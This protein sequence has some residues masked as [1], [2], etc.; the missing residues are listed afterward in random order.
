MARPL[1]RALAALLVPPLCVSCREPE[2]SGSPVCPACERLM[3]AL[4]EPRCRAC[5]APA[6]RECARCGECRGRGLAFS[7]AWAPFAYEGIARRLVAA[8]KSHG[9]LS[10]AS[11]MGAAVAARAPGHMLGG[12]L[13]P[14]PAHPLR[15]RRHGFNQARE[16]AGAIGRA[17]GLPVVDFLR[18]DATNRPQVGLERRAR[19]AN[20]RRSV[21][22]AGGLG[23]AGGAPG[24]LVLVDDVYTTG[25]TLDACA[26]ALRR[27]GAGD[28]RALTF[29]R[30][31]RT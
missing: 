29:V 23:R 14:V 26:G 24:R 10:A 31:V 17:A 2:L 8:L 20:A 13:V 19:L 11:F 21:R 12:V 15:R 7:H 28:V 1:V 4:P 6:G 30:A 16:I 9:A 22:V 27:A 25:A 5:G 18:R 3:V